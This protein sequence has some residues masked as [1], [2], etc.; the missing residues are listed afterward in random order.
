MAQGDM[1][2]AQAMFDKFIAKK[3]AQQQQHGAGDASQLPALCSYGIERFQSPKKNNRRAH[4]LDVSTDGVLLVAR[5]GAPA[6]LTPG[7][8]PA[9]RRTPT[10]PAVGSRGG[11][12]SEEYL[13]TIW[14]YLPPQEKQEK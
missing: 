1:V 14:V 2:G 12:Y 7:R 3:A 10:R 8:A 11:T 4:G 13:C 6:H 9:P 5:G